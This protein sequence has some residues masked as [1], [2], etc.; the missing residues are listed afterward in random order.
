[1]KATCATPALPRV[2]ATAAGPFVTGLDTR[3]GPAPVSAGGVVISTGEVQAAARHTNSANRGWDVPLVM[4]PP[5]TVR[6]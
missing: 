6:E 4:M 1:M 5:Q 2:G 3:K